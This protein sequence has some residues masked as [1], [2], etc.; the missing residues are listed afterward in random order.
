[1]V[2]EQHLIEFAAHDLPRLRARVRLV[3]PEVERRGLLSLCVDELHAVL[4]DEVALLHLFEHV[5]PLQDPVGLGNERFADMKAREG[6][7]VEE[8]DRAAVLG[9]EGRDGGPGGSAADDNDVWLI[10]AV[11]EVRGPTSD[12]RY[13]KGLRR[14]ATAVGISVDFILPSGSLSTQA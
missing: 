11:S 4:L 2:L 14:S 9:E 8:L 10:H 3:V 12:V 7:A 6:L 5:E 13:A 1:R